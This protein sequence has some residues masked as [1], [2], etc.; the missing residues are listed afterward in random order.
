MC[1][2]QYGWNFIDVIKDI[3]FIA[4]VKIN[5]DLQRWLIIM[6]STA[7]QYPISMAPIPSVMLPLFFIHVLNIHMKKLGIPTGTGHEATSNSIHNI[8][9]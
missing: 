4:S 5:F 1:L 7:H 2:F 3:N 8:I 6:F 9:S